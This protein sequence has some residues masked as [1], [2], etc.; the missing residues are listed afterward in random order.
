[1]GDGDCHTP[2]AAATSGRLTTTRSNLLPVIWTAVPTRAFLPGYLKTMEMAEK[3][4][5]DGKVG[6]NGNIGNGSVV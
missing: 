3:N 5:K 1:M 4:G 2:R 6:K